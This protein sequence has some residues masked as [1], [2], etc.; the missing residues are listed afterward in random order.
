MTII[1]EWVYSKTWWSV[2]VYFYR[3]LLNI[4]LLIQFINKRF[5]KIVETKYLGNTNRIYTMSKK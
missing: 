4:F 5:S 2:A 3:Q 1:E